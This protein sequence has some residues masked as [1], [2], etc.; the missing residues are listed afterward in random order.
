M[1]VPEEV[2]NDHLKNSSNLKKTINTV[3]IIYVIIIILLV[4]CILWNNISD[5][6]IVY[7]SDEMSTMTSYTC[8]AL[9][10]LSSMICFTYVYKLNK[11]RLEHRK[12]IK[13][14]NAF[15]R[16]GLIKST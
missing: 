14:I 8:G 10:F 13:E 9:I 6:N 11:K 12:K 1:P 15:L 3:L 16:N 5:I 7:K 2:F 4:F